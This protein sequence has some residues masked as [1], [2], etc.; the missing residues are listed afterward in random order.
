MHLSEGQRI[1]RDAVDESLYF[2]DE[3]VAEI[4]T[5]CLIPAADLEHFSRGL[6]PE[7][8]VACHSRL[9]SFRRT[10][11]QETTALGSAR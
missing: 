11:D 10:S 2:G 1:S 6:W 5:A 4:R 8:D 7:D 9:S 3:L